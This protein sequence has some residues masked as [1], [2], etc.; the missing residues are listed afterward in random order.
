MS[1]CEQGDTLIEQGRAELWRLVSE[2]PQDAIDRNLELDHALATAFGGRF[3][4]KE[5][6]KAQTATEGNSEASRS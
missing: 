5:Q 2:T 6:D 1:L 3:H 4:G